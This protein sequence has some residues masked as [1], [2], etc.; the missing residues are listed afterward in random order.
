MRTPSVHF[1]DALVMQ[2]AQT[3]PAS[4]AS[5]DPSPGSRSKTAENKGASEPQRARDSEARSRKEPQQQQQQQQQ[6]QPPQ[7]R[8]Q[9]AASG[10]PYDSPL[11]REVKRLRE[12]LATLRS[13][14][15]EL[16]HQMGQRS[17]GNDKPAQQRDAPRKAAEGTRRATVIDHDDL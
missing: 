1:A 9:E 13:E 6:Q 17:A 16:R 7:Q 15:A 2:I 10:D 12:E 4:S 14:V 5:D 3:P 8:R 11:G